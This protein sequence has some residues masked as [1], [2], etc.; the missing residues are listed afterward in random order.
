MKEKINQLLKNFNIKTKN[1]NIYLEAFA[2]KSYLNENKKKFGDYERLEWLGDSILQYY[3]SEYIYTKFK[4]ITPGDMTLIRWFV[5]SSK[6][7]ATF[8]KKLNLFDYASFGKA[9]KNKKDKIYA[10]IFES[11]IGALYIDKQKIVIDVIL[12]HTL[13]RKIDEL[14]SNFS[15]LKGPKT[16][17][18]EKIQVGKQKNI[19][20]EIV[21]TIGKDHNK[22]FVCELLLDNIIM[23]K[24]KGMTKSEAETKAAQSALKK[25]RE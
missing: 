10:D 13:F 15:K 19:K 8:T 4:K 21:E 7:L 14:S 5:V 12:Q 16:L 18:Q 23:G 6:S 17:F 11:F 22:I 9:M 3:V 20:Y 2:H 1:I 24:G 25:F